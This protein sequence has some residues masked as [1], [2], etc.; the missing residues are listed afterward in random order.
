MSGPC[1]WTNSGSD[2][3]RSKAW[4]LPHRSKVGSVRPGT[5]RTGSARNSAAIRQLPPDRRRAVTLFL[6]G[7]TVLEIAELL[8]CDLNRAHNLAYRG[9]RALKESM[10]EAEGND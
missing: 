2:R 1:D 9:V 6:Q 4:W 8:G 3:T 10:G 5:A 7:F